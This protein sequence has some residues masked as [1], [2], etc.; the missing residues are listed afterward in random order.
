[1]ERR[2]PSPSVT[3]PSYLHLG[4]LS[5]DVWTSR[6][7][8][9]GT[10]H[11]ASAYVEADVSPS[12]KECCGSL[13]F[14]VGHEVSAHAPTGVDGSTDDLGPLSAPDESPPTAHPG[15]PG[16]VTRILTGPG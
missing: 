14:E 4:W 15:H 8:Q 1:M 13:V 6:R 3:L 2:R 12:H 10:D 16:P 9:R 5:E 7:S 11:P